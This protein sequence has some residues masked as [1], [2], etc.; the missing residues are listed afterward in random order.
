MS[1]A[2][3]RVMAVTP[4]VGS[5]KP[6]TQVVGSLA[7]KRISAHSLR[8]TGGQPGSGTISLA[9]GEPDFVT[10]PAIVEAMAQALRDGYTHYADSNGDPELR[11]A[12]AAESRRYSAD[13]VTITHGGNGGLAATVLALVNPGDRVIIPEPTYSLYNDLVQMVGARPVFVPL[14]ENLRLDLDAIAAVLPG[15]RMIML[16]NPGNPTGAVIP[17]E[18]LERL[19]LLLEGTDTAVVADEAYADLVYDDTFTTA[20]AIDGLHD[21]LIV[22]NTFSKSFAMTGWRLGYTFASA[23]LTKVIRTA[24]RTFDGG[25]NAAIQRAALTAVAQRAELVAPQLAEYR[26]R[27]SHLIDRLAG[28]DLLTFHEPAGAFYLFADYAFPLKSVDVARLLA[29]RGVLVRAGREYGPSGEGSIRL[30]FASDI[31]TLTEGVT[32]V[33]AALR[34]AR[35][36][37]ELQ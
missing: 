7:A 3:T 23:A 19:A 32:R 33:L 29:D 25:M 6:A 28:T 15:A 14:D 35:G 1:E 8:P 16:C 12:L 27:R 11:E 20:A 9:L 30:S 34:D 24:H 37:A 17:R 13:E 18:Q 22:C 36:C 5:R 2:A 21:R 10:P 4:T 31:P 26:V